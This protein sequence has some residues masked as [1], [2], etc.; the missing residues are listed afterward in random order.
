MGGSW[1]SPAGAGGAGLVVASASGAA[2]VAGAA[3]V[4]GAAAV[5]ASG[6]VVIV[7]VVSVG[8]SFALVVPIGPPLSSS[9]L[10][11]L[12]MCTRPFTRMRSP[13][14]LWS[15]PMYVPATAVSF[16]WWRCALSRC[17]YALHPKTLRREMGGVV[18]VAASQGDMPRVA[19]VFMLW[20]RQA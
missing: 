4:T 11:W 14:P 5:V 1:L 18:P 9:Y 7:V 20:R 3:V 8:P 17:M 15:M 12:V 2:G 13:A 10:T 16:L 6:A 19:C